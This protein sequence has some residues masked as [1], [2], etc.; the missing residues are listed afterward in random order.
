MNEFT[1]Q[2]ISI[3]LSVECSFGPF[4]YM[5]VNGCRIGWT[6]KRALLSCHRFGNLEY[7]NCGFWLTRGNYCYTE[8]PNK[9]AKHYHELEWSLIAVMWWKLRIKNCYSLSSSLLRCS[10]DFLSVLVVI[11]QYESSCALVSAW[12]FYLEHHSLFREDFGKLPIMCHPYHLLLSGL[13]GWLRYVRKLPSRSQLC[14]N[15]AD[16]RGFI[17]LSPI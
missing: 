4:S 13:L 5:V 11:D 12:K 7:H 1:R 15:C 14:I 2:K 10:S 16:F 9:S 8:Y 6:R 3:L 17:T